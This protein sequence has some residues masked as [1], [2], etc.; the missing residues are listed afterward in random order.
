MRS[1][2]SKVGLLLCFAAATATAQV[3][4]EVF[5]DEVF[6]RAPVVNGIR[7]IQLPNTKTLVVRKTETPLIL[8]GDGLLISAKRL[9]VDGDTTIR[10]YPVEGARSIPPTVEAQPGTPPDWPVAGRTNS[11]TGDTGV[12]GRTGET[13]KTGT[14]GAPSKLVR[15]QIDEVSGTGKLSVV[16]EGQS[17]GK[18]GTGQMGGRGQK[19]GTGAEGV[20]Q[21]VYCDAGGGDG[22]PGGLGGTGGL[23]GVG[24]PGGSGG[25]ILLSCAVSKARG[26]IA[27]SV[28]G[29]A[30]GPGGDG[31]PPGEVG[32]G[33]DMGPG[34]GACGGGKGGGSGAQGSR[35]GEGPKGELG[36]KGSV[37]TQKGCDAPKAP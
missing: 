24:G 9:R 32:E 8:Y 3:T 13:G 30:R 34:K 7:I 18:G 21:G 4:S 10:A 14:T 11:R 6:P 5:L 23:G 15:L 20:D 31:G 28:E 35:G 2:A 33:G 27:F 19:G 22:G 12:R 1:N 16:A 36:T 37:T 25:K 17:G 29:G 26:L